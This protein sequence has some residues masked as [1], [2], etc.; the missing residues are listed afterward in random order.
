MPK[1]AQAVDGFVPSTVFLD[2]ERIV[3]CAASARK[4]VIINFAAQQVVKEIIILHE[5]ALVNSTLKVLTLANGLQHIF[6]INSEVIHIYDHNLNLLKKVKLTQYQYMQ[7]IIMNPYNLIYYNRDNK[8]IKSYDPWFGTTKT[9][10]TEVMSIPLFGRCSAGEIYSLSQQHGQPC[11]LI[12]DIYSAA[13][14]IKTTMPLP[15]LSGLQV[16]NIACSN[17][18][19]AFVTEQAIVSRDGYGDH[20]HYQTKIFIVDV[21][22]NYV[23]KTF[24]GI[25]AQVLRCQFSSAGGYLFVATDSYKQGLLQL[26]LMTGQI[27]ILEPNMRLQAQGQAAVNPTMT[28]DCK[29]NK[30]IY[31]TFNEINYFCTESKSLLALSKETIRHQWDCSSTDIVASLGLPD[32]L[33]GYVHTKPGQCKNIHCQMAILPGKDFCDFCSSINKNYVEAGKPLPRYYQLAM[34]EGE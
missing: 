5:I 16:T 21:T 14:S 24:A 28:M 4:L 30:L 25:N 7:T 2:A 32:S 8:E 13:D 9:L 15:Y 31:P 22:T 17:N 29:G 34:Q 6:L 10:L 33:A 23:I 1:I 26:G 3:V 19:F 20:V 11:L 27:D 18:L 12:K